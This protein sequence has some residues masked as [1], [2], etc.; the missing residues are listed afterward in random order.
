MERRRRCGTTRRLERGY[1]DG[2]P[3]RSAQIDE[4]LANPERRFQLAAAGHNAWLR[5]FTWEKL[6]EEYEELYSGV[7]RRGIG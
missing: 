5:R 3:N 1:V 4:L 6:V 2:D 7:I